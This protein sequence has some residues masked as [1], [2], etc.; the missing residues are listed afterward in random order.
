MVLAGVASLRRGGLE[1]GIAAL[2]F[3]VQSWFSEPASAG[4]AGWLIAWALAAYASSSSAAGTWKSSPTSTPWCSTENPNTLTCRCLRD[5]RRHSLSGS[6]YAGSS[7]GSRG[8][9]QK[10]PATSIAEALRVRAAIGKWSSIRLA[11]ETKYRIGLGVEKARSTAGCRQQALRAQVRH[12]G[13]RQR[14]GIAGRWMKKAIPVSISRWMASLA[15][16]V[17]AVPDEIR[18]QAAPLSSGCMPS[19]SKNTVMLTGDNGVVARAVCNEIGLTRHFADWYAASRQELKSFS[20]C[21]ARAS[22]WRW[23]ATAST[24]HRP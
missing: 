2:L 21:S 15:G 18:P 16:L 7:L 19:A 1:A 13:R 17:P 24:I 9:R 4:Y 6:Y 11:D 14:V 22:R 23:S 20:R 3:A 12:R 8:R 5:D 10:T